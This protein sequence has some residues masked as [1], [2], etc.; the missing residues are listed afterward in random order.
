MTDI[1]RT[2]VM[3]YSASQMFDLVNAIDDYP[4]FIP[5]CHSAQIISRDDDEI[6]ATLDF[7][8]G[9]MHKSFT[10][11]NRLQKDKMIQIRLLNG[12]FKHLEGFWRFDPI[13]ENSCQVTFDL[14]FEFSN[15]LL[16]FAFGP[17]FTQVTNMLVD[18]FRKRADEVYGK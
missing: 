18:S 13:S 15:K 3:P 5:W 10:T 12:P 2:A 14:E 7:S 8:R 1:K 4:K 6:R 17:L 9:G 11:S 16:G